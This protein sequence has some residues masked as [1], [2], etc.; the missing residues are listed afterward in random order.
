MAGVGDGAIT[1]TVWIA[2]ESPREQAARRSRAEK[3]RRDVFWRRC[4]GP[5]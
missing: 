4:F 1:M 3:S 2:V 5:A